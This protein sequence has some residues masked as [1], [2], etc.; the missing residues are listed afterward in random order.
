MTAL[1]IALHLA[2]GTPLAMRADTLEHLVIAAEGMEFRAL[3]A[4]PDTGRLVVL[5]HGFPE[6]GYT[7]RRQLQALARAGYRAVAPDQRGYSPGARPDS[8]SAY[9]MSHLV[10]DVLAIATALGRQRFDLVG[11]DWGGAV[12]WVVATAAPDRVRTLTVLSTPHYAALAA[13]RARGGSDQSQ[14]S[15]YF[16]D[17]A[18]PDAVV[19]FLADSAARLRAIYAHHSA[20]ARARYLAVFGDSATLGAALAWYGAAFGPGTTGAAPTKAPPPPPPA[21]VAVP[22]LYLWGE[23]DS[24]FGRETAEASAEFVAGPYRFVPLTGVG[25]WLTEEASDTVTAELLRQVQGHA[26]R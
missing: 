19:R 18:A 2:V 12:A 3:A 11:H 24:A 13:G 26:L 22:T 17:F 21:K 7:W 14:R 4:G 15:G 16:T 10:G 25:H 5:L 1:L 9:G 23:R 8:V 6:T 20:A